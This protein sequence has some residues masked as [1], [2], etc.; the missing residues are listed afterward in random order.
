MVVKTAI[1][2]FCAR[3]RMTRVR[4][5][6]MLELV[7]VIAIVGILSIFAAASFN[8]TGFDMARYT[9]ELESVLAYAQKAAVAER[10]AVTVT[11]AAGAVS[12]AIC[13]T[14][15]PCG[16]TVPLVLPTQ[17]GGATLAAPSGVT[18]SSTA[19]TFSFTTAGGTDQSP[20]TV[21]LTVTG[22]GT[23]TLVVEPGTGYVH[24]G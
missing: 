10:R 21:T 1:P 3:N 7:A 4:G 18:V 11:V 14:F 24:P 12:F 9:R 6:T 5:F 17:N 8:R 13:S 22:D 15:N 23:R 19:A 20:A 16:G 2:L